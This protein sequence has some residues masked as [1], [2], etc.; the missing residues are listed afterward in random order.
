MYIIQSQ[1]YFNGAHTLSISCTK[2]VISCKASRQYFFTILHLI[3]NMVKKTIQKLSQYGEKILYTYVYHIV[4]YLRKCEALYEIT[5]FVHEML[6]VCA[7]LEASLRLNIWLGC[8][9]Y[10]FFTRSIYT[11]Y[12]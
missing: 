9:A 1:A 8:S 2:S 4:Y 3:C 5:D 6:S 7:P 12:A 11:F 10:C